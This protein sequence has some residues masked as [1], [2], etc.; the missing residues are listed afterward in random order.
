MTKA[1]AYLGQWNDSTNAPVPD[2]GW[3]S[4][5]EA[6]SVGMRGSGF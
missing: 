3:M 5:A 1:Y 2:Y 4:V 6:G